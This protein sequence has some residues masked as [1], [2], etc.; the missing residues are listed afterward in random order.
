VD[1]VRAAG[2]TVLATAE[3]YD[4]MESVID[5]GVPNIALA[6]YRAPDNYPASACPLCKAGTPVT[7]F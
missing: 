4:R 7:T 1:L 5:P 6:E 3:I 2:A